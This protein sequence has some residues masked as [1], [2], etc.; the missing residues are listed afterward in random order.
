MRKFI[1]II[2]TV[3]LVIMT[4]AAIFILISEP[5]EIGSYTSLTV[6]LFFDIVGGVAIYKKNSVI[7]ALLHE[8]L[9]KEKNND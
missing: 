9:D 8:T 1:E 7:Y 3:L 2:I 5:R 4:V 6:T